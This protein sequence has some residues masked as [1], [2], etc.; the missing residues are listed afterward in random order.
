MQS[1]LMGASGLRPQD[2]KSFSPMAFQ[3]PPDRKPCFALQ[4][5]INLVGP[6]DWIQAKGQANYPTLP[7]WF[8]VQEGK[9]HF[10]HLTLGKLA[11]Q[12]TMR[13]ATQ[14]KHHQAGGI[15]IKPVRGWLLDRPRADA[16]QPGHEAVLL[17]W[18]PSGH[19]Q[20][21]ARLINDRTVAIQIK[22]IQRAICINTCIHRPHN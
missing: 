8:P 18:A 9:I 10:R 21:P 15:H 5:I 22:Q 16:A 4:R 14:A 12:I 19:S 11:A 3:L 17:V 13:L 20:K 6:A 2:N 1:Q 7:G